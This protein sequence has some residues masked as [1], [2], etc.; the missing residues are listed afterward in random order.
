MCVEYND[1][2][3]SEFLV[4]II[5]KEN[6]QWHSKKLVLKPIGKIWKSSKTKAEYPLVWEIII[7]GKNIK[8]K[9]EA[10]IKDQEMVFG[11][12]NYWEGPLKVEGTVGGEKVGGFGFMELVGYPS[13]YNFLVLAGKEVNKRIKRAVS[14]KFKK[15]F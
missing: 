1:G 13:D 8:L 3:K 6:R 14:M 9:V 2:D 10:K 11:T 7:P 12:I 15:I 5:D 4:D